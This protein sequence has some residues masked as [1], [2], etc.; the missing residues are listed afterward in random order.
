LNLSGNAWGERQEIAPDLP[1][2]SPVEVTI[3]DLLGSGTACIGWASRLPA[4]REAPLRYIDLMGGSKP[5]L[6]RG[7]DNGL[8]REVEFSCAS[9]TWHYLKDKS[10]GRAWSTRMPFPVHCVRQVET[11]DVTGGSR[12]ISTYRYHHG[13]YDHVERVFR[14][15]GMVEQMDAEHFE[16]WARDQA[17]SVV[18]DTLHRPP[19]LTKTWFHTGADDGHPEIQDRFRDEH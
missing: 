1:T 18:D 7:Y 12:R 11:R 17:G 5:H 14:G 4:D 9:S 8:G 13:H 3:A 2:A 6:L 15:F 19:V 10:E 16:N